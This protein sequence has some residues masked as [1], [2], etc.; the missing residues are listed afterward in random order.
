[1]FTIYI[2]KATANYGLPAAHPIYER[3]LKVLPDHHTG[4]L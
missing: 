4:E 3:A 1:M 2:P